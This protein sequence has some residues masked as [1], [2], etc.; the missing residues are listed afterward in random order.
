MLADISREKLS[1]EAGR[2]VGHA[3]GLVQGKQAATSVDDRELLVDF[4][5][6]GQLADDIGRR[7]NLRA[8]V[9]GRLV[10]ETADA[11]RNLEQVG[12]REYDRGVSLQGF[13]VPSYLSN[14]IRLLHRDMLEQEAAQR[15]AARRAKR[16]RRAKGGGVDA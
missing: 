1:F 10:M 2:A 14:Y 6:L 4:K 15:L 7:V 13:C 12:T 8:G 16:G 5:R 3:E 11:L 9:T